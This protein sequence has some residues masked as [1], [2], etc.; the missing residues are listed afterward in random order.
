MNQT[1]YVLGDSHAVNLF[2]LQRKIRELNIEFVPMI[3]GFA[4]LTNP[5]SKWLLNDAIR[6]GCFK[7]L[8]SLPEQ[9]VLC[10]FMTDCDTRFTFGEDL[11]DWQEAFNEIYK[12]YKLSFEKIKDTTNLK[13]MI[14][15]D[16]YSISPQKPDHCY[17]SPSKRVFHREL[18]L[19]VIKSLCL[20]YQNINLSTNFKDPLFENNAGYIL[21]PD[22]LQ[23]DRV[24]YKL[25]YILSNG[26]SI[27]NESLERIYQE[28]ELIYDF[29]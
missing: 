18:V 17:C 6:N 24:H 2:S 10:T 9:S 14:I 5:N 20:E 3:A 1:L 12:Y 21:K 4:S 8:E 27:K 23:K 28:A 29:I 26:N 15:F 11:Q 22:Y 13:G 7:Y 25:D 16:F 19:E